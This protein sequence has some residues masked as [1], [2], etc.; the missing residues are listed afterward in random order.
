MTIDIQ[1]VDHLALEAVFKSDK[2]GDVCPFLF[3]INLECVYGTAFFAGLEIFIVWH[4][5]A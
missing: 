1:R 4:L 5:K 3:K 2:S